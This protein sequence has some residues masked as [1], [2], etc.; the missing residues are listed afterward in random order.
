[1]HSRYHPKR[2]RLFLVP[3]F[4]SFEVVFFR[5][6]AAV[7]SSIQISNSVGHT[8]FDH[9]HRIPRPKTVVFCQGVSRIL[10]PEMTIYDQYLLITAG[11]QSDGQRPD[12]TLLSHAVPVFRPRVEAARNTNRRCPVINIGKANRCTRR[13]SHRPFLLPPGGT[14]IDEEQGQASEWDQEQHPDRPLLSCGCWRYRFHLMRASRSTNA[15]EKTT[16]PQ[17]RRY[18]A[19]RS[20]KVSIGCP[21]PSQYA[22]S[23]RRTLSTLASTGGTWQPLRNCPGYR[24]LISASCETRDDSAKRNRFCVSQIGNAR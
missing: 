23:G 9:Q 19:I 14:A 11:C 4:D 12:V 1:M 8:S 10:P 21:G 18:G 2:L 22:A 6:I 7:S 3:L 13:I 16:S 17:V 5:L 24:V 20:E 15:A